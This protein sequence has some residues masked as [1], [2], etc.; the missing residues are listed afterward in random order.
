M[1]DWED[2]D[3]EAFM[4][5]GYNSYYEN[6]YIIAYAENIGDEEIRKYIEDVH[7]DNMDDIMYDYEDLPAAGW[8]YEPENNPWI[9]GKISNDFL[10]KLVGRDDIISAISLGKINES[11]LNKR[12]PKIHI[13]EALS[14][15]LDDLIVK[16]FRKGDKSKAGKIYSNLV[17]SIEGID[18]LL[19]SILSPEEI[20][21]LKIIARG[22]SILGR[23]K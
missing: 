21:N 8:S 12:H 10:K 16:E 11:V 1:G 13:N 9:N 5:F 17:N 22:H 18:T 2:G 15:I 6:L 20:K 4:Q 14:I 19:S 23:F 3:E 7:Q